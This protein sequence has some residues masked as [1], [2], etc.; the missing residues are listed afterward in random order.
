MRTFT[1]CVG[2]V[3]VTI[4][5]TLAAQETTRRV[6]GHIVEAQGGAPVPAAS[7]RINNTTIGLLTNDSG[8]FA[9]RAPTG[10]LTVTVRRIGYRSATVP[11]AADQSDLTVSLE[12]DVLKLDAEVITGVATS[13]ASRNS[14]NDVAVVNADQIASVPAP[15]I[16]NALQGKIAGAVIQTNNGGAPGGG[17]QI[18]IRGVTSIN[19]NA[20]PLYVID[21]VIV[22]NQTIN[23]D[24]N[25]VSG[26]AGGN[27]PSNQDN[28][29]NRIAD[30]N[31]NDIE[32]IEVLKGA[33]AAAIYGSKAASGVVVI[34][35]KKGVPGA[36][37]WDL[38]GQAGTY[39]LANSLKFRTFPTYASAN[40]WW[41]NDHHAS[42]PLPMS[43]YSPNQNFQDQLF[44]GGQLSG[45]GD[46]NVRGATNSTNY[47]ASV[48]DQYDN[49]LMLGTFYR[50]QG[51]RTNLTQTFSSAFQVSANL[52][53]Q[54]SVTARGITGNDNVG[55]SPY[56]IFSSTPQFFRLNQFS[57]GSW[58]NN[59][60][61]LANAFADAAEQQTPTTVNRFIGG[62][63]ATWQIAHSDAQ[64]LHVSLIGGVDLTGQKDVNYSPPS[65]QL[66]QNKSLVG[67]STVGQANN[68]Y[69]NYSLSLIHH[70]TGSKFLDATTSIGIAQDQ[71][72]LDNPL[73]IGQ[74]LPPG[75]LE[76]TAGQVITSLETKTETKTMSLY[77][78]EQILT[79]A[80]RLSLTAGITADRNSNNGSFS[81]YH[82]YPKFA[83]SFRIPQFIAFVDEFKLRAAYGRSGTAPNY[84]INYPANASFTPL[85]NGGTHALVSNF[86]TS[87]L[88]FG[89]QN[90]THLKP[91]TSTEIES[92]ADLTMLRSHVQLSA[93]VYQKRVS[94]LVLLTQPA[95]SSGV[96]QVVLNGGQFTNQGIEIQLQASP[97]SDPRG[98]TWIMNNTFY[99][100]YSRVDALPIPAFPS[101]FGF[102]GSFGTNT[103]QVGRSV[104]QIVNTAK[105]GPDGQGIQVGDATP[106]DIMSFNQ[107]LSYKHLHLSGVLD[108][109]VGG[110]TAN[111]TNNYY[112]FNGPYLLADSVGIARRRA[113]I[114][115]NGTPYVESARFVKLREVRLSY[116]L[117][118]S[119][120]RFIGNGR[121]RSAR[122]DLAGR[123]LFMSFPY[124]GLD[125]EVS[126][127]GNLQTAR[128]QDI[129]PYPPAKSIFVGVDLGL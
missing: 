49:G 128:G 35:T 85:L 100:N 91:E 115:A 118:D 98:F 33:S 52:Y 112:D 113:A 19:S 45:Q 59:P 20:S 23:S 99:R 81:A 55:V 110:N 2:I 101:L 72:S 17:L 77:G 80:Q 34:T 7:V 14:A 46:L 43:M 89:I 121:L 75:I 129:T 41:L 39:M 69:F 86:L 47:Y 40:A 42:T 120:V 50:K 28:N 103:I 123:N 66:E 70:F 76:P 26:A 65:L 67:T 31:P 126:V 61:G 38:S 10:A 117:P 27:L 116:D 104:S 127:F 15:T 18:Q 9:L 124:T 37:Q 29:A 71:R 74:A 12:R 56:N 24:A 93:T 11:V 57:N 48:H 60:F 90:D 108:W 79:L 96:N 106:A 111:I 94:D 114:R 22:N 64:D 105:L 30:L 68:E 84:G 58:V 109:Y 16:E 3:A 62:G 107:E 125:P 13:I 95:A 97:V 88:T 83:G 122:I 36:P 73:I 102:G 44:G 54:H 78:Q 4:A 25:A 87:P 82:I 92:G 5:G 53:Y 1:V 8:A 119:W 6:T 51:V 63:T 32:T 21:G